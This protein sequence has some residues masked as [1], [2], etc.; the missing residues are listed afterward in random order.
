MSSIVQM[1][2]KLP[3]TIHTTPVNERPAMKEEI[4]T[5]S[6]GHLS[7]IEEEE[8]ELE[9]EN[10]SLDRPETTGGSEREKTLG[11]FV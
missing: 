7:D 8:G 9:F 3:N 10:S 5:G 2:M 6:V 4:R 11:K 1:S